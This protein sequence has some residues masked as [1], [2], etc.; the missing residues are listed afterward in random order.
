MHNFISNSLNTILEYSNIESVFA[1]GLFSL[2]THTLPYHLFLHY[3]ATL[4]L[5]LVIQPQLA[6][7]PF[8]I[9]AVVELLLFNISSVLDTVL[10]TLHNY[11]IIPYSNPHRKLFT[12]PILRLRK[13]R[14][15]KIKLLAQSDE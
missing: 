10:S 7:W 12:L 13:L 14:L 9:D 3:L 8:Y 5:E 11:L 15:S 6:L 2:R 1:L 4:F